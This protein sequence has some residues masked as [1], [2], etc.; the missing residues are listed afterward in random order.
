MTATVK[1]ADKHRAGI[2]SG[3]RRFLDDR[4]QARCAPDIAELY[5]ARHVDVLRDKIAARAVLIDQLHLVRAADR[6]DKVLRNRH[7]PGAN[8]ARDTCVI[9]PVAV[10]QIGIGTGQKRRWDTCGDVCGVARHQVDSESCAPVC[11]RANGVALLRT[12]GVPVGI[13]DRASAGPIGAIVRPDQSTDRARSG[14][15]HLAAGPTVGYDAKIQANQP[16]RVGGAGADGDGAGRI[17]SADTRTPS[18]RTDQPA[19]TG[20]RDTRSGVRKI[21]RSGGISLAKYESRTIQTANQAAD[22]ISRKP[23]SGDRTGCVNITDRRSGNRTGNA[24]RADQ[25]TDRPVRVGN[26]HGRVTVGFAQRN[27]TVE[28]ADQSANFR[29]ATDHPPGGIAV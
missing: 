27:G 17:D 18:E 16:T 1:R 4:D 26:D 15:S 6:G 11:V 19:R 20:V 2:G 29:A 10:G 23:R 13:R 21:H 3:C 24:G 5:R 14:S 9:D 12:V 25:A 7:F 28:I 8:R 22:G